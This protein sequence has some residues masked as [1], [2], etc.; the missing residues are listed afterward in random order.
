MKQS[1]RVNSISKH[2]T[3]TIAEKPAAFP[4]EGSHFL[5]GFLHLQGPTGTAG[6]RVRRKP[7]LSIQKTA[8]VITNGPDIPLE[9]AV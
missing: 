5:L 8:A 2:F 4:F 7:T 6:E 3:I 1:L 9:V